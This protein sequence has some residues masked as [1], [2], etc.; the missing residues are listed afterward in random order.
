MPAKTLRKALLSGI[1]G[2]VR[3]ENTMVRLDDSLEVPAVLELIDRYIQGECK[4]NNIPG[5]AAGIVYDQKLIWSKGYGYADLKK[6]IPATIHTLF[7]IASITKVFTAMAMMQLRDAGKLSLDDPIKKHIPRFKLKSRFSDP[8]PVTFRQAAS[9]TSGMPDETD[10]G[11]WETLKFPSM[12]A[13]LNSLDSVEAVRPPLTDTS[14]SSL[15]PIMIGHAV[16]RITKRPYK[17]YLSKN[18]LK[19]LGMKSTT[20]DNSPGLKRLA[21]TGYVTGKKGKPVSAPKI[22]GD[23][24]AYA[25]CGLMWSSVEDMAKFVSLQ[26]RDL[27]ARGKQV[28]RGTSLREMRT[29]ILLDKEWKSGYGIGWNVERVGDR[30][31]VGHTGGGL[32]FTAGVTFLPDLKLGVVVLTNCMAGTYGIRRF[33]LDVLI[34]VVEA[35]QARH[36]AAKPS[37][38]PTKWERYRGMYS[39]KSFF[40]VEVN[41]VDGKLTLISPGS[42][43]SSWAWLSPERGGKFR[44][45]GN[46]DGELNG[47]PAVFESDKSGRVTRL[48]IGAF[49]LDRV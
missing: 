44:V 11:Q 18:L 22:G 30:V 46:L 20:F 42:P 23:T 37:K 47:E 38:I 26:F 13:I 31:Y 39:L 25:P 32:G 1:G 36:G 6:K 40:D 24:D 45:M 14:Y 2:N 27:P 5:I 8:S 9:H 33:A 16:E 7:A 3:G 34:P 21:A 49:P 12:E 35:L 28:L 10:L 19:P 41:I 4:R 17:E 43:P 48:R 15:G 29:P